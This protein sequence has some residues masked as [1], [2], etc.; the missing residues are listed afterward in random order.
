M[1]AV[2]Y[3]RVSTDEQ[4]PKSQLQVVLEYAKQRGYEVIRTFEE[5]ISGSIDPFERPIFQKLLNYIKTNGIEVIVMYDLT[6]FYRAAS[7]TDTLN[8]LRKIME[9]YKVLVD[10]AREPEVEDPLLK[11]LWM[12]IKSWFSSYERLQI[13]LRTRYGMQRVKR[14]GRLYHKPSIVHYFA[15]WLFNKEPG[16]VSKEELSKAEEELR[17]IVSKYWNMSE[18]KRTKIV[19]L[20]AKNELKEMYSRF[21]KAPK[22]FITFYRFMEEGKVSSSK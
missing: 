6:R 3:T 20:L 4:N 19:E 5:N 8:K 22:S 16:E 17:A 11:E 1:K 21:P 10:F 7:P 13:S 9:E 18:I 15:A 2:A 12:F 14:E